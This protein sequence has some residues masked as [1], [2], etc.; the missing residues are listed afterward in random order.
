MKYI[1]KHSYTEL[2][3]AREVLFN[4][5]GEKLNSDNTNQKIYA[6]LVVKN[7]VEAYYISTHQGVLFDPLGASSRREN[8]VET[9]MKRVS[10][11]TFDFYMIYLKTHNSIYMTKAQRGYLND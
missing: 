1:N 2:T 8:S 9:S 11:N 10:K 7:G 4:K 3:N 5:T 6:K